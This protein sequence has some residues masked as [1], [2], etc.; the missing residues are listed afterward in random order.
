VREESHLN[1]MRAA[2]RGDFERLAKRR[3]GQELMREPATADESAGDTTAEP[4]S[5]P[6]PVPAAPEPEP[7]PDPVASAEVEERVAAVEETRS[8]E[9][10]EEAPRRSFLDRLLG[11]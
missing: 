1:D 10:T 9:S 5:E 11:R 7:A 6:E 8:D 3:G 4:V 2:I